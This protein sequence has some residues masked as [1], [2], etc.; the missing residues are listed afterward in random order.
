MLVHYLIIVFISAAMI[1]S[2]LTLYRQWKRTVGRFESRYQE[3]ARMNESKSMVLRLVAHDLKNHLGSLQMIASGL[4]EKYQIL[5]DASRR[6]LLESIS[7]FA[8][9][10]YLLLENLLHWSA[11]QDGTVNALPE[12]VNLLEVVED[13][14]RMIQPVL[15]M[16]EI[17]LETEIPGSCFIKADRVM[18]ASVI[19]NLLNNAARHM[20][21]PGLI[22]VKV[23]QDGH[24]TRIA[25][26]DTGPGISPENL[27]DYLGKGSSGQSHLTGVG[28]MLCRAFAE[29]NG[30]KISAES[31]RGKGSI[32]T[33]IMRNSP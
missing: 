5:D 26:A 16:K 11:M 4:S 32:F 30:G 1:L 20:D 2:G 12:K 18:L 15:T 14:I 6:Q 23:A 27:D 29:K 22:Q 10:T 3:M 7:Q 33:F 25:V 21:K 19:R 31:A 8:A 24:E 28:L 13:E 9:Q 17:R